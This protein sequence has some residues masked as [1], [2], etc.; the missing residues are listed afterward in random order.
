[1]KKDTLTQCLFHAKRISALVILWDKLR[2]PAQALLSE[3][4][5]PILAEVTTETTPSVSTTVN[6]TPLCERIAKAERLLVNVLKDPIYLNDDRDREIITA[7]IA[8]C[9][10]LRGLKEA[11]IQNNEIEALWKKNECEEW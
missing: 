11:G 9:Q 4:I 8:L 3:D 1:M 7:R 5:D 6:I 2:G 10:V